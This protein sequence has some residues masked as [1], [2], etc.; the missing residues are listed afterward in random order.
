MNLFY[1]IFILTFL[2]LYSALAIALLGPW[3]Y[4]RA[5]ALMDAYRRSWRGIRGAEALLDRPSS[6]ALPRDFA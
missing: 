1:R 4:R 3:I 5:R 6:L 2:F